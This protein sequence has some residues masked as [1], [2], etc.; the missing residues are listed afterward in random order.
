MLMNDLLLLAT[1]ISLILSLFI[2]RK[3]IILIVTTC[4]V[5][6]L[7]FL[8]D[9]LQYTTISKAYSIDENFNIENV[10]LRENEI[11]DRLQWWGKYETT[12]DD[13]KEIDQIVTTLSKLELKRDK[14]LSDWKYIIELEGYREIKE[15]IY[16][17]EVIDLSLDENCLYSYQIVNGADYIKTLFES[18]EYEWRTLN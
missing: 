12:I 7:W 9:Q 1:I 14:C 15:D 16:E 8:I 4:I 11:V 3:I 13:E 17:H 10:T 18:E 5:L 6:G 2:E